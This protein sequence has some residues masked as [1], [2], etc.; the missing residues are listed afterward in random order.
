MTASLRPSVPANRTR[1]RTS[2]KRMFV[3]ARRKSALSQRASELEAAVTG[4]FTGAV[5]AP[6]KKKKKKRKAKKAK[7]T[8][9]VVKAARKAIKRKAT[10]KKATRKKVAKRKAK[11]KARR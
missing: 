7:K 5:T 4:L 11:R 9:K 3:M 8:K 6:V 2:I 10:K 1:R